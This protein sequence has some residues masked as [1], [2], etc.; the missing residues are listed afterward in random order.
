MRQTG[1]EATPETVP[2]L[3]TLPANHANKKSRSDVL[4]GRV[5]DFTIAINRQAITE[6]RFATLK[7]KEK[8]ENEKSHN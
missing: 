8:D 6:R 7:E 5:G 4:H 1:T 3:K 2:P